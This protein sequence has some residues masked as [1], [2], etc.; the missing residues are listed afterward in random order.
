MTFNSGDIYKVIDIDSLGIILNEYAY[1]FEYFPKVTVYAEIL[2]IRKSKN[3]PDFIEVKFWNEA[4]EWTSF[5]EVD[6]FKKSVK[7]DIIKTI[8]NQVKKLKHE[9]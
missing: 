8:E 4:I 5:I 1:N 7:L 2:K 3:I 9:T 6:T